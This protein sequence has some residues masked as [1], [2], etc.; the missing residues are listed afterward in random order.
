MASG[1]PDGAAASVDTCRCKKDRVQMRIFFHQ[2]S[3]K[4]IAFEFVVMVFQ[5]P[6]DPDP[7]ISLFQHMPETPDSFCMA[8]N[9]GGT[10]DNSQV[11]SS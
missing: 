5:D 9:I 4:G 6:G 7:G 10:G 3:G 2:L 11:H 8:E 1:L